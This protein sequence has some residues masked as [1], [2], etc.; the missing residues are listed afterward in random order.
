MLRLPDALPLLT[1]AALAVEL[2]FLPLS[3]HRTGRLV[4]WS[5]LCSLH[6]GIVLLVDF[7]DLSIGML[8]V[9]LFTF[10]LA[11]IPVRRAV[12]ESPAVVPSFAR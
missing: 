5:T 1:W 6:V 3:F 2:L 9:H 11:W 4:A 10:D 7:A 8:M 12:N